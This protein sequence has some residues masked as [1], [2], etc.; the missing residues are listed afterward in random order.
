MK[1]D[2]TGISSPCSKDDCKCDEEFD[3]SDYMISVLRLTIST[4]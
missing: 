1:I 3:G 4:F 2:N